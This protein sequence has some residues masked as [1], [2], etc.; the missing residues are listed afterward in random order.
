MIPLSTTRPDIELNTT[1][2]LDAPI[3]FVSGR[4]VLEIRG[5]I[6]LNSLYEGGWS[7]DIDAVGRISRSYINVI[8]CLTTQLIRSLYCPKHLSIQYSAYP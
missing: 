6:P 5:A 7:F 2:P 8:S 1:G 3:A 4:R